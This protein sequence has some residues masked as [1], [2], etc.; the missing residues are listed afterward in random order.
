M[1]IEIVRAEDT[2]YL[3]SRLKEV[4]VKEEFIKVSTKSEYEKTNTN[5]IDKFYLNAF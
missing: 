4:E 3:L 1:N 5:I 2:L